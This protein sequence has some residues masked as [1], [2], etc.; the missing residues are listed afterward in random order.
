MNVRAATRDEIA[1]IR[2]IAESSFQTSY[3]LSPLEIE[4]IV[5]NVFAEDALTGRI[6]DPD[7]C[8]L[9]VESEDEDGA[10]ALAGFAEL[11]SGS[12]LRWLHVD[13]A[14]R[15]RGV[16]SALL[17]RGR[18]EAVG[19]GAPLSARILEEANEG[20]GFLEQFGL[21]RAETASLDFAEESFVEYVYRTTGDAPDP[22]EP[23]VEVPST[24]TVDG[25]KL[26]LDHDEPVPG[27]E[28]PFFTIYEDEDA[29]DA[30]SDGGSTD[31]DAGDD[32]LPEFEE[33]VDE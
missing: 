23:D 6:D 3:S 27:T 25:A 26:P 12:T 15:G 28:A 32:L 1:E 16:A 18:E 17:E 13:P 7:D 29:D 9:V 19:R 20:D 31:D 24:V 33:L 11:E 4:T 5:E 8:V 22:E 21:E 2:T 10:P 30:S 14:F